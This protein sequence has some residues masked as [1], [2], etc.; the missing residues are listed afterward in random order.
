M[1]SHIRPG[2]G[3]DLERINDIYNAYIVDS[4][5]SFDI[6]PWTLAERRRW[7][8]KYERDEPRLQLLVLEVDTMVVGFASSS[9]F[10]DKKAYDTSVETTIVL[11]E[12]ATGRGWG[13][14]LMKAL[15]ERLAAA[16]V[17]RAYALIALPNEPSVRFHELF[18]Y[19][20]LGTMDEVGHK[21]DQ[22]HSVLIMERRF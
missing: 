4:H 15:L 12:N 19:T 16:G 2:D 22:F 5:T 13:G 10:R 1:D 7:Y 21:L 18:G 3:D 9:P 17:H 11:E 14:P 6:E 20:A 8:G